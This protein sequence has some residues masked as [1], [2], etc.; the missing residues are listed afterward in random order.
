MSIVRRTSQLLFLA[1]FVA[2]VLLPVS[3][4]A[5]TCCRCYKGENDSDNSFCASASSGSFSSCADF[6]EDGDLFQ[7]VRDGDE[8]ES[9]LSGV[10]CEGELLSSS[11]C[12]EISSG[13]ASAQC[14]VVITD[15]GDLRTELERLARITGET[16]GETKPFTSLTPTLGVEIPGLKLSPAT[17][18]GD[19]VYVPFLAEYISGVYRFLIGIIL[20]IA[21]VMVVWGGF[22]YLLGS[23]VGDVSRGKEII[24][25]AL[26][27]MLIILGAYMILQTVNPATLNLSVLRLGFVTPQDV[28]LRSTQAETGDP[29]GSTSGSPPPD[30]QFEN[31]PVN[32]ETT[33]EDPPAGSDTERVREFREKIGTVVSGSKT[34]QVISLS[35]AAIECGLA[36]GSCG[37]SAETI[38]DIAGITEHNNHG[39]QVKGVGTQNI[40]YLQEL[41][42]NCRVNDD[43]REC[44]QEARRQAAERFRSNTDGWPDDFTNE[45]EPGDFINIFTVWTSDRS[46]NGAGQHSA[47]FLGWVGGGRARLFNGS[48]GNTVRYT[49]YCISSECGDGMYPITNV[50][51][52]E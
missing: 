20:I 44:K 34:E 16:D 49:N 3:V 51:K 26:A 38:Y 42:R 50:W 1:V 28:I 48:W 36:M 18:S 4:D 21:I 46:P 14:R 39:R 30:A 8:G 9:L 22:R 17:K 41:T 47:I 15:S 45:L 19:E 27:G 12:A 43:T 6:L 25:D 31:C 33:P 24:R 29:Q 11:A 52:P 23:S 2:G 5:Q 13:D 40:R 10:V 37:R 35:Q 7:S 32:L